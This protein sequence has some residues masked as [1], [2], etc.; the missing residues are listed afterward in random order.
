MKMKKKLDEWHKGLGLLSRILMAMTVFFIMRF[1]MTGSL[2][3]IIGLAIVFI[4]WVFRSLWKMMDSG[5][6]QDS[7]K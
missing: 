6:D 4:L 1:L 5:H 3:S 2:T 7:Q